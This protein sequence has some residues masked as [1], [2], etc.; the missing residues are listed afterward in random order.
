MAD[1][2]W[3]A[4]LIDMQWCSTYDNGVKYILTV[5]DILVKHAW[6]ISSKG[7]T[8]SETAEA[9]KTIF[10]RW[11]DTSEITDWPEKKNF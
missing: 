7:K 2:Q 9:F 8:S 1:A 3:Q 5:T 4:D 11:P 10:S 6:T